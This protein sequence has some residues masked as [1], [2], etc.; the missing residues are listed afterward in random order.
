MAS[1]N[2]GLLLSLAASRI[3]WEH[4]AITAAS[5]SLRV[6]CKS[7]RSAVLCTTF[8]RSS[9]I[10]AK[11]DAISDASTCI[12]AADGYAR[13]LRRGEMETFFGPSSS[14]D[15]IGRR[16]RP[17]LSRECQEPYPK[18]WL[19]NKRWDFS[20][21]SLSWS[22]FSAL[23]L[24][25]KVTAFPT[26]IFPSIYSQISVTERCSYARGVQDDG[27]SYSP[28]PQSNLLPCCECFHAHI[29]CGMLHEE[30][31]LE[32]LSNPFQ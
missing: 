17:G 6:E 9:K 20:E 14:R 23:A 32:P 1:R 29:V 5:L 31:M 27:S 10:S 22:L 21:G 24:G 7:V 13:R 30:F 3:R 4:W 8:S 26:Q 12:S 15:A 19:V 18:V 28:L 16:R 25:A 11:A 2:A